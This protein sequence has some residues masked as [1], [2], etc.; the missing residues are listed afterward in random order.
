MSQVS[1]CCPETYKTW[2]T[3]AD[4]LET[5]GPRFSFFS[6]TKLLRDVSRKWQQTCSKTTATT[7]TTNSF[8]ALESTA[9]GSNNNYKS[10]SSSDNNKNNSNNKNKN[11]QKNKERSPIRDE[12]DS[13]NLL[14]PSCQYCCSHSGVGANCCIGATAAIFFCAYVDMAISN[15]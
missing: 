2:A 9:R 13:Q 3:S 10:N 6:P 14:L 12:P 8:L 1:I 11:K 15:K 4:G 5:G 7:E